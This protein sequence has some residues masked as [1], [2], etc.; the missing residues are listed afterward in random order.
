MLRIIYQEKKKENP[1]RENKKKTAKHIR[2]VADLSFR[3]GSHRYSTF[4]TVL[5]QVE[6]TQ[7]EIIII[8]KNKGDRKTVISFSQTSRG[9]VYVK[10]R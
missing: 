6:K 4:T 5:Q 3:Q 8:E 9:T 2:I 7:V 10:C 1:R